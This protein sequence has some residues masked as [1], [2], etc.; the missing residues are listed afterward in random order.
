[1]F[2]AEPAPVKEVTHMSPESRLSQQAAKRRL[3][4][5]THSAEVPVPERSEAR[6]RYECEPVDDPE[7]E[8]DASGYGYGV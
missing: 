1:M 4:E 5:E 7:P 6:Q 8:E 3:E 2:E